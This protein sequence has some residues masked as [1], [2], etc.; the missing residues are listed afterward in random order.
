[1][2]RNK[3]TRK[4][5]RSNGQS[6]HVPLSENGRHKAELGQVPVSDEII[7]RRLSEIMPSPENGKL[8]KPIDRNDPECLNL[9]E[10]YGGR[11]RIAYDPAADTPS[12]RKDPWMMTIPC[13]SGA[14]IYPYGGDLLAVEVDYH[15]HLAKRLAAIPGVR[16]HQCGEAERTFLFPVALF[17]QV[18]EVVKPRVK[19]RLTPE[20]RAAGAGHLAAWREKALAQSGIS[21]LELLSGAVDGQTAKQVSSTPI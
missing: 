3:K 15:T 21:T 10:L 6:G 9:Q 4:K 11:Y 19:R 8:Y 17:D 5:R 20:Q 14:V 12:E 18:A 2:K 7:Y 13:R 16:P 1:M